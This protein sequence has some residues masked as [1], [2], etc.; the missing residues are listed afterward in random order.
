VET[1]RMTDQTARTGLRSTTIRA[2]LAALLVA[3]LWISARTATAQAWTDK[4][5]SP[6]QRARLLIVAMTSD[7][8]LSMVHGIAG[9]ARPPVVVVAGGIYS[10]QSRGNPGFCM[11]VQGAG[12]ANGTAVQGYTCNGTGAQIFTVRDAG[13]GTVVLVNGDKCIDIPGADAGNANRVQI[14]DCNNGPGQLLVLTRTAESAY[15]LKNAGS[16]KCIEV[17]VPDAADSTPIQLNDCNDTSGQLF[18]PIEPQNTGNVP[19]IARLGIPAIRL[20]DGPA[21]V[22]GGAGLVT[23][24]P[25]PITLA[26]TWDVDLAKKYGAAQGLEHAGKGVNVQLGPMMNIHRVPNAGRNF[27]GFGEDPFLASRMAE[28]VVRGIQSQGVIATAKHYIDNDHETERGSIS[29]VIDDRTQHEI[30]LPPFK[31][32]VQ[33]G[34]GAVMCSYNRV[35]GTYACE[36]GR[37]QNG[38]LKGELG[39]KGFIMSDWGGTHSTVASA[40]GGLDMEMPGSQFFGA[41]LASAVTAETVPQSRIDDMVAR[42][43][44]SMFQAG[45]FD[46]Q[47]TG[48][49]GAKVTSDTAVEI[50]R[51]AGAEGMVLLKNTGGVL[52]LDTQSIKS[53]AVIGDAASSSP[54]SQGGGSSYVR[55]PY[56]VTARQGIVNRAGTGITVQYSASSVATATA[57]AQTSDVAVVV[58]GTNSGEGEDR[59]TI[60]LSAGDDALVS[61]IVAANPRTVV[62]VYAPSQVLLPWAGDVPAI[63]FGFLP[64]QEEG[65]AL[66]SVLFGDVNPCGKLPFTIASTVS[67]YPANTSAQFPGD[68]GTAQY[69]EGFL[70][71]YRHFD[72]NKIAPL[73]AFGHGLSYSAFTYA[74]LTVTPAAIGASESVSVEADITNT[75]DAA[76]TEVVQLYVGQPPETSEPPAQ[77]AGFVKAKIAAKATQRVTF[78]VPARAY[79]FWS[80]GIGQWITYPGSYAIALGSS[81]RDIRLKGAFDLSGGPLSGTI[82]QAESASLSGGAAPATE[83]SGYTGTGY[84][85]GYGAAGATTTFAVKAPSANR[86]RVTVRYS[87]VKTPQTLS[88][89]VNGVKVAQA[90]FPHLANSATWD[91][92]TH[93]LALEAGDNTV[94]YVFESG[95]SG[96]VNLD[97]LIIGAAGDVG[98]GGADGAVCDGGT[99][100]ASIDASIGVGPDA[101]V[102]ADASAPVDACSGGVCVAPAAPAAEEE[103]SGCDCGVAGRG[104]P[105][106]FAVGA[107]A[108]VLLALILLRTRRRRGY[109]TRSRCR[110]AVALEVR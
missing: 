21:G 59:T 16:N 3:P 106:R 64:G 26:A 71:G 69:S 89:R 109:A 104:R 34:V 67:D 40:I 48:S 102:A 92:A 17:Q 9:V 8:K 11:D 74:N 36:N 94:A 75:S 87:S 31:A 5:M 37:T 91:F 81:S 83:A 27:E 93:E 47:P 13:N 82:Y 18:M 56:V 35:N 62:V 49:L 80:A 28:A 19:G 96:Q 66:A 42:I 77:L 110:C 14:S 22:G 101:S 79:S 2:L 52:P 108:G 53:I 61:A 25:A 70:V 20:Q 88:V 41:A 12:T 33:A 29:I 76:G 63:L 46:R 98:D 23:A 78:D 100:D 38:W 7:E 6:E 99:C 107:G 43:L 10:L 15:A 97:A 4:T 103:S 44:T 85:A 86:Y 72:A 24:F 68:G 54:I 50:A 30:Y 39:F 95:D 65:N 73:F 32:S 55:E 84:V 57:A 105:G 45:L 1:F 51:A 60:A 90:K 58:V